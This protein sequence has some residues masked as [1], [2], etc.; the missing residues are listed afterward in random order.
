M[1]L[2]IIFVI[3]ADIFYLLKKYTEI[4]KE[5]SENNRKESEINSSIRISNTCK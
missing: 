4:E 3:S 2:K 1:S 5:K